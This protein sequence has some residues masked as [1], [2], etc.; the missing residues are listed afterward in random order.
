M[1]CEDVWWKARKQNPRIA[2]LCAGSADVALSQKDRKTTSFYAAH[3]Y[4]TRIVRKP[5]HLQRNGGGAVCPSVSRRAGSAVF[6]RIAEHGFFTIKKTIQNKQL[7][8]SRANCETCRSCLSGLP[9][10]FSE[11]PMLS[12]CGKVLQL[13][14]KKGV[15]NC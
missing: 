5:R 9:F 10:M 13:P 15:L 14:Y 3:G 11:S 7:F 12:Y 4:N 6:V 1:A 8:N 2:T